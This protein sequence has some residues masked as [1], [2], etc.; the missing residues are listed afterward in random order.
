MKLLPSVCPSCDALLVVTKLR[1]ETCETEVSGHY[2]L[3]CF[4]KLPPEDQDFIL[5][6]VRCS[7][8]LKEMA[9]QLGVS[10]PTVRNR[11]NAIIGKLE[12]KGEE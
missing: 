9:K 3:S 5:R 6:F 8:S 7:G 10:Y 11:I 2:A 4:S 12:E 1:C